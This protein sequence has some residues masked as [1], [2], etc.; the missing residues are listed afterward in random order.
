[1]RSCGGNLLVEPAAGR[2]AVAAIK[3]PRSKK[4]DQKN[5]SVA[6]FASSVFLLRSA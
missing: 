1:M 3:Y 6:D 4:E 5:R 2:A